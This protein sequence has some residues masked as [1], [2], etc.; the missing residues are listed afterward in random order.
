VL[1]LVL[2]VV[3]GTA[4]LMGDLLARRLR[5]APPIVLLA[6]GVLLG[7]VPALRRVELPPEMVLLLFLPGLLYWESITTSLREIRRDLRGI[8]L[9][10]TVLVVV[11]AGTVAMI[12]H[13]LGMPLGPA[14][15]L[16]AALAPTD[17]TAVGVVA[18]LLPR[19][20]V[21]LVRAESLINDGTALVI[22]GLAV[23]V[24][25]GEEHLSVPNVTWQFLVA[26]VGAAVVGGMIAWLGIQVRRRLDDPLLSNVAIIL[27][28]YTAYLLAEAIEASGVLAVVL[29]GLIMS[30]SG[31]RVGQAHQRR[32]TEAFWSLGAFLL[33]GA[34]FVLVGLES[35]SAVRGLTST[36][37]TQALIMVVAVSVALVIVRIVFQFVAI[38]LIRLLDRRPSQRERRMS[39]RSR[40]VGGL[41]GFRGAVSLAAALGVPATLL[42]GAPFPD[43]DMIIFVTFGVIVVTVVVQGL[44][45]PGVVR[46]ARLAPDSDAVEE[47]Q[48]LALTLAAQE[49]LAAL[50]D[51]AADLGASAE[52]T[53]RLRREYEE[54]LRA[55]S[56]GDE[57][58]IEDRRQDTELRL[59]MLDRKRATIIRLRDERRIDDTALRRLQ[60]RL[61]IEE[62]RLTHPEPVD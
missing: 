4:I 44:V 11:T 37:I 54:H 6:L 60:A 20:G 41:V 61:D 7:F 22:Y 1:G 25:V 48:R 49:A 29:C 52:V 18:R 40:I 42:S 16:G 32:Q 53:D 26:Y 59:A 30:Q 34:L 58:A 33:N 10:G 13:W 21:T 57:Q 36:T 31:P 38:Y 45:L 2:V 62:I 51:T 3:L 43:R 5:I 9:M 24:T 27:I 17:A 14:W 56:A 28:P 15:V 50:A 47:E 35:Q 23:A 12:A 55:G 46:W 8:V 19:R 39:H